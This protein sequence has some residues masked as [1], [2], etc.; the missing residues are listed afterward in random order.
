MNRLGNYLCGPP[1]LFVTGPQGMMRKE[2]FLS[3]NFL[4][5]PLC[6]SYASFLFL[7]FL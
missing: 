7:L 4:V 2:W 3:C 1:F 5:L 6:V